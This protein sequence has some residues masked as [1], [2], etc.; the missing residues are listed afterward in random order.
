MST[1]IYDLI[2]ILV[3]PL[4]EGYYDSIEVVSF[5]LMFVFA[6]VF[7]LI[8]VTIIIDRKKKHLLIQRVWSWSSVVI[9]TLCALTLKTSNFPLFLTCIGLAGFFII[10]TTTAAIAF[11]GEVTYPVES[12]MSNG[13]ISLAGH[14][15]AAVVGIFATWLLGKSQE[16][17]LWFFVLLTVIG[18]TL[19]LFMTEDLRRSKQEKIEADKE[20]MM[21]ENSNVYGTVID[22]RES[23][24]TE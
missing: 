3:D 7:G 4:T 15:S 20:I 17:T 6:G 16:A 13:F 2:A 10:P 1:I 12:S 23:E 14:T 9:M 22:K 8:L 11:T 19:T 21:M 24:E 18:G 5:A